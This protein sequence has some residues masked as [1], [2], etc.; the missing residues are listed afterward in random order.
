MSPSISTK[1]IWFDEAHRLKRQILLPD[2]FMLMDHNPSQ[3]RAL[4]NLS[5]I[6]STFWT[7]SISEVEWMLW[8]VNRAYFTCFLQYTIMSPCK[9]HFRQLQQHGTS[10]DPEENRGYF[11]GSKIINP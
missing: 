6:L 7:S 8:S 2:L 3:V 5:I 1:I 9:K 10:W 11:A 4:G